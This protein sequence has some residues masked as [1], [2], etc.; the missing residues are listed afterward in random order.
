MFS[1]VGASGCPSGDPRWG[2]AAPVGEKETYVQR[3]IEQVQRY[4]DLR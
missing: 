4:A 3:L 1:A 2:Y